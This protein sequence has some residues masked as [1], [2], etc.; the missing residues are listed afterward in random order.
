MNKQPPSNPDP[1]G[2]LPSA[3]NH[4]IV[5]FGEHSAAMEV[6]AYLETREFQLLIVDDR[7]DQLVR[8]R[9]QGYQTAEL[10]FRDDSELQTLDL[11]DPGTTVFSLFDSDAENVFLIISI[12]AMSPH[13]PIVTIAQEQ[14][15]V[16]RLTAAGADRVIDV[17]E[18]SGRR[19]WDMFSNP[20][21]SELL[22]T[23]L[24]GK[25]AMNLAELAV[26]AGSELDQCLTTELC[27]D[28]DYNLIVI[29]VVGAASD[30]PQVVT[31]PGFEHR[32]VPGDM[33]LVI[34]HDADI[35]R[36]RE[37]LALAG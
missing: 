15:T 9:D 25:A 27:L 22:E 21:L 26:T 7:S 29:G 31:T 37:R 11:S 34:G 4:R 8:A 35:Q 5:L 28:C 33:L 16:D 36:L 2:A 6:A 24:F 32:L 3:D 1:A 14:A 23:T 10:D 12:R 20:M 17:H 18:I 30:Q 13:T 19:I